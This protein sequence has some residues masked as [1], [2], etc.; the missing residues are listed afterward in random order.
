MIKVT[1]L[2]DENFLE[3]KLFVGFK[4]DIKINNDVCL[5]RKKMVKI[6]PDCRT[7]SLKISVELQLRKIY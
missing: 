5:F 3:R 1:N 4:F 7:A 2:Y 6:L